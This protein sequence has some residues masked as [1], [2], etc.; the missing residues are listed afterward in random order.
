[1]TVALHRLW[2]WVITWSNSNAL[3][4]PLVPS[5]KRGQMTP[6]LIGL[7][8]RTMWGH[9]FFKGSPIAFRK[10]AHTQFST[11]NLPHSDSTHV[12]SEHHYALS[13]QTLSIPQTHK[14]SQISFLFLSYCCYSFKFSSLCL[15]FSFLPLPI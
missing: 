9:I 11:Q 1:M 14:G 13:Y 7:P 3:W 10:R 5:V 4:S 8:G 15:P 12:P 6:F 2:I